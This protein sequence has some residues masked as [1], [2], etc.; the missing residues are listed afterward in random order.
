MRY[1]IIQCTMHGFRMPSAAQRK[2]DYPSS[3][4]GSISNSFG[5]IRNVSSTLVVQNSYIENAAVGTHPRH[6]C[7]VI[8]NRG[9]NAGNVRAVTEAIMYAAANL[10]FLAD[11][12]RG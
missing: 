3:H 2:A 1:G 4:I 12:L 8:G 9:G 10:A 5:H 6:A 7:S 11:N